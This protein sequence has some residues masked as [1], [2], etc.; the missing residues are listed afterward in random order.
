MTP[1]PYCGTVFTSCQRR[2]WLCAPTLCCAPH[3]PLPQ[4]SQGQK[5]RLQAICDCLGNPQISVVSG[6]GAR[7]GAGGAMCVHQ[8]P[9]RV[10]VWEGAGAG[11]GWGWLGLTFHL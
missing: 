11:W 9:A 10:Y 4:R 3:A 7:H 8:P 1:I 6:V 5:L 2:A